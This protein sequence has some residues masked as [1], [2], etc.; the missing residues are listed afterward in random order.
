MKVGVITLGCDK[1]TVD[2]E[3]YLA[4]LSD[5]SAEYT[6]ELSDADVIIVNTCGFIDAAKKESID[7]MIEAARFKT[8]GLCQAVVAVGCMIERHKQ[9]LLEALPEVDLFLGSSEMQRLVPELTARGLLGE[10]SDDLHPGVRIYTG[11]LPHVRY[12]KIS[13]GC[14]HG[15][16]FCA[17][18]LMRGK[19]VLTDPRKKE[20]GVL[21]DGAIVAYGM[22]S[23]AADEAHLLNLCTAPE[24]QGEGHGRRLLLALLQ[25]AR[26][27]GAQRVFLEVRPSNTPAI[28]LYDAEGFN[29]IGRRPRYYPAK[30]G[31]EACRVS[32]RRDACSG[33]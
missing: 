2:S 33:R 3:R 11:D 8:D 31:R 32:S 9:E 14:D 25:L 12:M 18:P 20:K 23:I 13:E 24:A 1:N 28:A 26:G 7:A 4:Q 16:A 10:A 30:Q 15:C 5:F 27:R 19:H 21:R 6:A 22:L 29:E 17:I